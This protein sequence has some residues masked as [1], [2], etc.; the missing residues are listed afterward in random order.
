MDDSKTQKKSCRNEDDPIS[1]HGL[2][3]DSAYKETRKLAL[4]RSKIVTI[5]I[6]HTLMKAIQQKADTHGV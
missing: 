1:G 4:F 2:N 5:R 6:R 3:R